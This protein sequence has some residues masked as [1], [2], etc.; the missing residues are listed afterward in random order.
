[1][2]L[3]IFYHARLI[4]GEPQVSYPNTV[5]IAQRQL[6]QFVESGLYHN[7]NDFI[8]GINGTE[9]H[10]KLLS[11]PPGTRILVHGDSANSELPTI[12]FLKK[13]IL[14]HEDWYVCYFHLKGS[15]YTNDPLTTAWR[16][17]MTHAVIVNWERCVRDLD[18]GF[19]S[20]GCHWL[21]P[22]KFPTINNWS[23]FPQFPKVGK[24]AMWGGN[25]WWS[26]ASFLAQLPEMQKFPNGRPDFF[27]AE[28]WIGL[29]Q[30]RPR[31]KDYGPHWPSAQLC[32]QNA[33]TLISPVR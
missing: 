25:F 11:F 19:E 16:D 32:R 10:A 12:H 23:T 5:S 13:W 15:R 2:K 22:E 31:I 9:D 8:V 26:K 6:N 21:V 24:P 30:R 14:G 18:N 1:M 29:G 17:C 20:V 7:A 3:A 28:H 4:G 33:C 27:L